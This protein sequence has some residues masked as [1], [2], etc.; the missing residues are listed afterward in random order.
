MADDRISGYAAG[1]YEIARSEGNLERL[2]NELS[3]VAQAFGSN[4]ELRST[5][6]D[7]RVPVDRKQSIISDLIGTRAQE[8]TVA[9][10]Q[11]LVATDRIGDL[12]AIAEA[13]SAHAASAA[14]KELATV[15]SA[16]EL[17]SATVER[18][19]AALAKAT[20]KQVDVKVVVDPSVLGGLVATV[21]DTVIDGSVRSRLNQLRAAVATR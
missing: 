1:V 9:V 15:R 8:H 3:R 6:T 18:L 13:L 21:G 11:F 4:A 16:V 20:G 17:D 5:L 2:E 12:G 10:I 14:G 19:T 7:A